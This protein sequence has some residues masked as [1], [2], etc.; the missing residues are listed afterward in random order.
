M[1]RPGG[2]VAL[3]PFIPSRY[4]RDI[5]LH[6]VLPLYDR[7]NS[8]IDETGARVYLVGGALRDLLLGRPSYDF[9]FIVF[10]DAEGFARTFAARASGRLVVLD[11]RERIYRV[12]AGGVTFD[13]SA[14]KG[15]DLPSDLA[16]RDFTVNAMAADVSIS[17]PNVVSVAGSREDLADGIVRAVSDRTFI[18]DPLRLLRAFRLSAVL[19]FSIDAP[20]MGQI[21]ARRAMIARI[22]RERIRDEWAR[23]LSSPRSFAAVTAMDETGLLEEIFPEIAAMKGVDQNRWHDLDV[24]GHCLATLHQIETIINEPERFFPSRGPDTNEYF[25]EPLGG[26]WTRGSLAKLTALV[27]DVGKP[28]TRVAGADGQASFHGHENSGAEVFVRMARRLLLGKRATRYG[29]V[30]IKNHMRL[31]SLAVSPTLTKRAVARLYRDTGDALPALLVLGLADTRAGR[32][33]PERELESLRVIDE[34]LSVVEEIKRSIVPLL[35]GTEIMRLCGIPE[36]RLVGRLKSDLSEA[37]AEGSVTTKRAA[38]VFVLE[39]RRYYAEAV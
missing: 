20:T 15:G 8:T 33:D 36:G 31:L 11:D 26:G 17:P 22:A 13:F 14:P 4:M 9:D 35:S 29:R 12:V 2:G 37:Q 38:R 10:G 34:V 39:R 6:S 23:L 16:M 19:G 3:P 1:Y 21:E 5:T 32:P 24:W 27:H 18:D 7:L 25:A 30:L 28:E